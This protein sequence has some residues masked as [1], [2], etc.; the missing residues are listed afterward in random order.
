MTIV[1]RKVRAEKGTDFYA[2]VNDGLMAGDLLFSGKFRKTKTWVAVGF[3]YST[4]AYEPVGELVYTGIHRVSD[5]LWREDLRTGKA[6][7][8]EIVGEEV[9]AS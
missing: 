4:W 3:H 9:A 2:Y 5:D 6:P 7:V 1:I 8:Q